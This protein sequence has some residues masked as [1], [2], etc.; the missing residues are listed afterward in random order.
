LPDQAAATHA[1]QQ[2]GPGDSVTQDTA[3]RDGAASHQG[4]HC[5]FPAATTCSPVET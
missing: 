5:C 1:R 3:V 4:P 2:C